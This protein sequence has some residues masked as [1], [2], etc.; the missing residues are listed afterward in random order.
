MQTQSLSVFSAA[1][2]T[3]IIPEIPI[4]EQIIELKDTIQFLERIWLDDPS[5][6]DE[7]D[8][9]EWQQFMDKVYRN[10]EELQDTNTNT[11][12]KSEEMQ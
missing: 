1:E 8:P 11:I 9:S 12:D 7:I 6:R 4:W 2:T 3:T 10:V 5:I